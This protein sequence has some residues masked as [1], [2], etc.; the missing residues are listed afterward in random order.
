MMGNAFHA[1]STFISTSVEFAVVAA[2]ETGP[3]YLHHHTNRSASIIS[4][5]QHSCI[6]VVACFAALH[7]LTCQM[8]HL[9][10]SCCEKRLPTETCMASNTTTHADRRIP[11]LPLALLFMPS[12]IS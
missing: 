6:C 9:Q 7:G 4:G 12:I 3:W 8:P 10:P 5:L 11:V 2:P 1:A